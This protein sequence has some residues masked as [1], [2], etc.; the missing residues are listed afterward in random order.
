MS[1]GPDTRRMRKVAR[2]LRHTLLGAAIACLPGIAG[3]AAA[4][5][6]ELAVGPGSVNVLNAHPDFWATLELR[7][8]YR[9]YG[10]GPWFSLEGTSREWYAGA[11]VFYD[12]ALS[13]RWLFTPSFGFG[14][15]GTRPDGIELGM[16]LEFRTTLEFAYR[17]SRHQRL[18]FSLGHLSNGEIDSTNPGTETAK[19][20]F[21]IA[22]EPPRP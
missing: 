16:P 7:Q 9:L 21:I 22:L 19:I 17:F 3:A 11:G 20:L 15:Y 4:D 12:L 1:G 13:K 10:I 2:T 14:F 5:H 18:A 8:R 6:N